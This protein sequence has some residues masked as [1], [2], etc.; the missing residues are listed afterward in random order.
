MQNDHSPGSGGL[1]VE[2]Y[3]MFWDDLKEY[4]T[5]IN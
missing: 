3:K 4:F 5:K 2:F 1:T